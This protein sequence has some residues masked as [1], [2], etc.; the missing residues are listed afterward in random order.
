MRALR[1]V[2]G[3]RVRMR[4]LTIGAGMRRGMRPLAAAT[5]TALARSL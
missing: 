1:A 3:M 5:I 4:A 2:A